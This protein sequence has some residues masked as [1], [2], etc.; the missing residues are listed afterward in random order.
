MPATMG[1]RTGESKIGLIRGNGGGEDL[2]HA[3]KIITVSLHGYS[4]ESDISCNSALYFGRASKLRKFLDSDQIL[5][6][7]VGGFL[8][9]SVKSKENKALS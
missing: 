1:V 4:H 9:V 7:L 6:I 3:N 2:P 8:S 5:S